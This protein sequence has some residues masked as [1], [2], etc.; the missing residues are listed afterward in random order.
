M[1]AC[2]K[3]VDM[4]SSFDRLY[5]Y[6]NSL[7][8]EDP[9][10]GYIFLFVNRS[11]TTCKALLWDGTG[12]I[13]I[14]KRLEEGQFAKFNEMHNKITMT[15]SEFS[16]YIEGGDLRKRFIESPV[17]VRLPIGLNKSDVGI[18]ASLQSP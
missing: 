17:E 6:A 1:F 15:E 11:R 13:L 2:V 5:V 16:L 10:S 8:G 4:R 3:P 18:E 9:L 12:L 14:C 7:L